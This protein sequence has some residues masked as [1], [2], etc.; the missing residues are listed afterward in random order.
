MHASSAVR[1]RLR[2]AWLRLSLVTAAALA[3]SASAA[4][5]NA[6]PAR[7]EAGK[8]DVVVTITIAST[9]TVYVPYGVDVLVEPISASAVMPGGRIDVSDGNGGTCTV[10]DLAAGYGRCELISTAP[11][12]L[13]VSATYGGDGN[14]NPGGGVLTILVMP[15]AIVPGPQNVPGG[16]VGTAYPQIPFA[17]SGG[18]PPYT[19]AVRDGALPGGLTLSAEGVLSGTPHDGGPFDFSVLAKDAHG[20]PGTRSY[21]LTI[22]A[23]TLT[24]GPDTLPAANAEANYAQ[25]LAAA[26]GTGPYTY[27]LVGTLPEGLSLSLSGELSGTALAAGTFPITV[28]ATDSSGGA[29][30][31]STAQDYTLTVAAPTIT[32]T[33]SS[34]PGGRVGQAYAAA[35]AAAGGVAPYT[36]ALS[37][38]S[39]PAGLALSPAGALS[40]TPTAVGSSAFSLK[41]SDAHGFSGTQN[42]AIA[43]SAGGGSAVLLTSSG[44][45]SRPGQTVTFTATVV[46]G[47]AAAQ[48]SQI[49]A[50]PTGTVAFADGATPLATVPLAADGTARYATALSAGRHV[51]AAS[52]SGDA[53]TAPA[54]AAIV[55]Q[56][57]MQGSEPVATPA[58]DRWALLLLVAGLVAI[59]MRRRR[60]G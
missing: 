30:P 19:Y 46:A 7:I 47:G 35:I 11:Q 31:Y 53:G 23:P 16:T 4:A 3:G 33:P 55:Q 12:L 21:T 27:A 38:G 9:P 22:A 36:Y 39:L 28:R 50:V 51:I 43:V 17:A 58:L 2:N 40:G 44:S 5:P 25:T 56:V 60:A 54:S 57:E 41:A 32:L 13:T 45:P 6:A 52:Y 20:Y 29:G 8:G 1:R 37:S 15:P 18:S 42:Y 59:G 14:F 49:A 48:T 26:G 34:L 24:L 10:Q